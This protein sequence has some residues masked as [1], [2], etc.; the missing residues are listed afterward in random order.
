MRANCENSSTSPFSDS[1]SPMMVDVHSCTRS[2]SGGATSVSF[3]RRRSADSWMG[4]SGFL[5]SCASRRATSRHAATFCAR[6]SGVTSSTTSTVPSKLPSVPGTRVAAAT[7][8]RS[9]PSR[10]SATSCANESM[11]ALAA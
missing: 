4:V 10:T 6:I 1:T 8:W 11:R 9:R 7:T 5:I 2:C 3:R